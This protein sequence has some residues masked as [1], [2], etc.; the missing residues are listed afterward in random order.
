V[1]TQEEELEQEELR[2]ST[3]E[4]FFDLVFVFTLTQLTH[5]LAGHLSWQTAGRV[6]VM[7]LLLFWMYAGYAY[8]TNQVPPDRP[9]RR[10]LVIVG[11]WA[12]LICAL[13][14]PDAFADSGWIFGIGYLLVVVVHSGLYV[15]A[16][17]RSVW[18]FVPPN[19][20]AAG[21]VLAGGLSQG[22]LADG[23]WIAAI[24]MFVVVVPYLSRFGSR[25][26]GD[27]QPQAGTGMNVG[28]FVERH[29][30]L[31]IV[32]F[33]ESVVAVGIGLEG[34]RLD[35]GTL[36]VALLGLV[37]ATAL[38]WAFFGHDD[39]RAGQA[40]RAAALADRLKLGLQAYFYAFVP[41]LLGVVVL[42]A[43]VKKSI[44]HIGGVLSAG[45]A[46]ALAGG[47]ALYLAGH[48]AFRLALGLPG[49]WLRAVPAVLAAATAAIGVSVTAG[50]QLGA[51]VLLLVGMLLAD[52]RAALRAGPQ[53]GR[54]RSL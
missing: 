35:F 22:R 31:L 11:M 12:F 9:V 10:L 14:I 7:F 42:A 18:W 50:A 6:L 30:L 13:A 41:M 15:V 4:L 33:G 49:V 27:E 25:F 45:P 37:L 20:L 8:L 21:L 43:G 40:L 54:V 36:A 48:A 1:T 2:V 26:A 46:L 52:E 17:G 5:V 29:G 44:G 47:V 19:L 53:P 24:L 16:Y 38:W 39:E 32:A 3:L 51:L 34:V 28:H 23:L